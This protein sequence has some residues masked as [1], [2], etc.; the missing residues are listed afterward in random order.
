MKKRTK[1]NWILAGAIL[2]AIGGAISATV[3]MFDAE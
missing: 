3:A 2:S 1:E